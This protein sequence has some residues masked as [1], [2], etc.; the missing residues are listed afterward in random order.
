MFFTFGNLKHF[1][2]GGNSAIDMILGDLCTH[3]VLGD[4]LHEKDLGLHFEKEGGHL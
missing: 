4:T 3:Y 1:L 2:H